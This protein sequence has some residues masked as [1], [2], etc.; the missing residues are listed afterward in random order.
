VRVSDG[1]I[2][3]AEHVGPAAD[4]EIR[5]RPARSAGNPLQP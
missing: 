1:V 5:V 4:S 2:V 3:W